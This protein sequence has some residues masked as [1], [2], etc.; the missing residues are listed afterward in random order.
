[1]RILSL[2]ALMFVSFFSYSQNAYYDMLELVRWSKLDDTSQE[3]R[4]K[5]EA[6]LVKLLKY[7]GGSSKSF[8]STYKSIKKIYDEADSLYS[9]KERYNIPRDVVIKTMIAYTIPDQVK[10]ED[11]ADLEKIKETVKKHADYIKRYKEF[12]LLKENYEDI[13]RS[14]SGRVDTASLRKTIGEMY[15]AVRKDSL[16]GLNIDTDDY[17]MLVKAI[18]WDKVE[19][20]NGK[21]PDSVLQVALGSFTKYIVQFYTYSSKLKKDLETVETDIY[22]QTMALSTTSLRHI[23]TILQK[24]PEETKRAKADESYLLAKS[25]AEIKNDMDISSATSPQWLSDLNFPTQTEIIDA[26][27]TYLVRRARQEVAMTFIEKLNNAIRSDQLAQDLFPATWKIM[28]MEDAYM[29]PRFGAQWRNAIATDYISLPQN[30]MKSK[31]IESK[32]ASPTLRDYF[33]DAVLFGS[34]VARKY[35]FVDIVRTLFSD[36]SK[37]KGKWTAIGVDVL[38]IINEELYDTTK[39]RYWISPQSFFELD[40]TEFFCLYDLIRIK[41]KDKVCGELRNLFN[42]ELVHSEINIKKRF[43][44]E[45][46][47]ILQQFYAMQSIPVKSPDGSIVIKD[48]FWDTQRI[49]IDFFLENQSLLRLKPL[50]IQALKICQNVFYVYDYVSNRNYVAAADNIIGIIST[51]LQNSRKG[52]INLDVRDVSQLGAS[53]SRV[54]SA[55]RESNRLF[56]SLLLLGDVRDSLITVPSDTRLDKD[57][58]NDRFELDPAIIDSLFGGRHWSTAGSLQQGIA[59]LELLYRSKLDSAYNAFRSFYEQLTNHQQRLIS[60]NSKLLYHNRKPLTD[61]KLSHARYYL[62]KENT[63]YLKW[64]TDFSGFLTEI[65]NAKDRNSLANIIESRAMPPGSYRVKRNSNFSIDLN[66]YIG[67]YYGA[68]KIRGDSSWQDVYGLTAPI[69][70][71]FT[72]GTRRPQRDNDDDLQRT[73][74]SNRGKLKYRTQWSF[75]LDAS[76]IDIGAVVSYRLQHDDSDKG[77]PSEVKWEQV[78]SLGLNARLGIKGTPFCVGL[79][80]QRT[81][82]LRSF[83]GKLEDAWR[84]HAGIA[85]D[86]P[87]L[88]IHRSW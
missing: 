26:I 59:Q 58:F 80:F 7:S 2:T 62:L 23:F 53:G 18:D 22:N 51:L 37:M 33:S 9:F 73:Y 88:N 49:F 29:Q 71:S 6:M 54:L 14:R 19:S 86:L 67:A 48:G 40:A 24:R 82:Q 16:N 60:I 69:G 15:A 45:L 5:A 34:Y 36:H 61:D 83:K 78:L 79:G 41:Y 11:K 35:N 56:S 72:W 38:Y 68:E 75:T 30:I 66:A 74:I 39:Q 27:A 46:L 13:P 20:I 25:A 77:L 10:G 64:L 44:S 70:F 17:N 81:P 50:E 1:M 84:F 12:Q 31:Y 55:A 43:Y 3:K 8:D 65:V 52:L 87:L 76:F 85:L 63:A 28:Q 42:N 32:I 21:N 57:Y 47:T 4:D